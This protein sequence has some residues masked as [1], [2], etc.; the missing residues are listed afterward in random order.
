MA[1]VWGLWNGGY[2]YAAGGFEDIEVFSSLKEAKSE[3]ENRY[4]SHGPHSFEYVNKEPD[5][6][7][8]PFV[9]DDCEMWLWGYMPED[10]GDLYPGSILRLTENGNVKEEVT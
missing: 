10:T 3:F 2:S 7:L 5:Y 1:K 8:T 9:E 6:T 4:R